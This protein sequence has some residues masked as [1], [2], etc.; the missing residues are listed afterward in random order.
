MTSGSGL[1]VPVAWHWQRVSSRFLAFRSSNERRRAAGSGD[2]HIEQM[3]CAHY[4][5][6]DQVTDVYGSAQSRNDRT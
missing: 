6:A 1:T 2:S 4:S 3:S 5:A